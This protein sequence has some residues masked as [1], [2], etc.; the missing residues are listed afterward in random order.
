MS[1]EVLFPFQR[2]NGLPSECDYCKA[3]NAQAYKF[4][5]ETPTVPPRYLFAC[6]RYHCQNQLETSIAMFNKVEGRISLSRL[7]RAEPNFFS[8]KFTIR[9]TSGE[10]DDDWTIPYDW[11]SKQEFSTLQTLRGEPWWRIVLVKDGNLRHTFLHE[12]KELNAAKYPEIDWAAIL[13]ILPPSTM[14]SAF[15][16]YYSE[17][18]YALVAPTDK[19]LQVLRK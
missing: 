13:N 14:S 10:L 4:D 1:E 16:D 3:A 12:L 15:L 6:T 7:Q 17:E 19:E 8:L 5:V 2:L 18:N 11:A 9:R